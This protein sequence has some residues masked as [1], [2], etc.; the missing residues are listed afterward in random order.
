MPEPN[1]E[2]GIAQPVRHSFTVEVRLPLADRDVISTKVV[3][4]QT[5]DEETWADWHPPRM[6]AFIEGRSGIRPDAGPA[7]PWPAEPQAG[8]APHGGQRLGRPGGRSSMR[9]R[10]CRLPDRARPARELAGGCSGDG[11]G[12][13]RGAWIL[14]G[15]G[16]SPHRS[17][18]GPSS[19]LLCTVLLPWPGL[20]GSSDNR[21]RPRAGHRPARV[22]WPAVQLVLNLG[23]AVSD[24]IYIALTIVVFAVLWLL[25]KG[26][27]RFER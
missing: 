5:D 23:V 1:G 7:E 4:V 19:P 21:L 3:H 18:L 26:V 10:W 25:V 14:L 9:T 24:V 16:M 11:A 12:R 13:L 8:R 27:E 2:A 17:R 15:S 20:C 6:V 22:S